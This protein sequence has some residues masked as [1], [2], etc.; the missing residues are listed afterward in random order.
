[1]SVHLVTIDRLNKDSTVLYSMPFS[2]YPD[3]SPVLSMREVLPW[4]GADASVIPTG[5]LVKYWTYQEFTAAMMLA[6][7]LNNGSNYPVLEDLYIPYMPAARQDKARSPVD[8]LL[9]ILGER[10]LS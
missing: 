4:S 3:N 2:L 6:Y 7:R 5:M 1:M 9:T 10:A 8:S